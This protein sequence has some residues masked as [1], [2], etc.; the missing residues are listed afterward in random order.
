ME[1]KGIRRPWLIGGALAVAAAAAALVFLLPAMGGNSGAVPELK[2]YAL[3]E[4]EY[5][6]YPK[7]IN[8]SHVER[9]KYFG[10]FRA[11]RAEL[12][13]LDEDFAA[14]AGDF[15]QEST[16]IVLGNREGN[17]LYSPVSFWI[18]L[19]MLAETTDGNT[20]QQIM[21]A[22]GVEDMETLRQQTKALWQGIYKDNGVAAT[23][24]GSSI[25]VNSD[26]PVR[27]EPL[28]ALAEHY[29]AGSY[30]V[31]MGTAEADQA[32]A[33]WLNAMTE[34]LLTDSTSKITTTRDTI[35]RLYSTLYYYGAWGSEFDP[36]N[37]REDTFTRADG[38]EVTATFMNRMSH[39]GSVLGGET[40]VASYL[41]TE[42]TAIYFVL[43]DEGKTVGDVLADETLWS[44]LHDWE[45]WVSRK[46]EWSVP[47]FDISSDLDLMGPMKAMGITDAMEIG[48]ANFDPL[49]DR[50]YLPYLGVAHQ[51]A[52]IQVDEKGV[53]AVAYTELGAN[54]G[55]ALPPDEIVRMDLNRPFVMIVSSGVDGV[56]LFVG[57]IN[58]PTAP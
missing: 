20:R 34:N 32:I 39:N 5:P 56:P 18:A 46:V 25:W 3:S 22:L 44:G 55:A 48:A 10:E 42:N 31:E 51:A 49:I 13:K 41:S 23:K 45:K 4:P 36:A 17:A 12:E 6:N 19:S 54:A 37:N 11:Y 15:S 27:Q 43:P 57:I 24:L 14:V 58:D 21:D 52:R 8:A 28:D 33:D 9:E 29:Y 1:K 35:M 26:M 2:D 47:K 16:Q 7:R 38:G 53:K 40:F 30:A 50:S